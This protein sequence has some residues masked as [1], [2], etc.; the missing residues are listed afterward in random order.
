MSKS[1]SS[2]LLIG[3]LFSK[4]N[5]RALDLAG[6]GASG[7]LLIRIRWPT[8]DVISLHLEYYELPSFVFL[9]FFL[10]QLFLFNKA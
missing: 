5:S 8:L 1:F 6:T 3:L 10:V 9:L 4:L 2:Y 7:G